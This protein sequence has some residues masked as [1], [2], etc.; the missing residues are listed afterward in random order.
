MPNSSRKTLRLLAALLL[1][2]VVGAALWLWAG[3]RK[4]LVDLVPA[5]A[6]AVIELES[7]QAKALAEKLGLPLDLNA[8]YAFITPNEYVA[9]AAEVADAKALEIT[10]KAAGAQPLEE[11]DGLQRAWLESGFLVAWKK[12]TVLAVGPE[13]SHNRAALEQTARYCFRLSAKKSFPKS[14]AYER[15]AAMDGGVRVYASI[16]ALPSPLGTLMRIALPAKCDA[17]QTAFYG[18]SVGSDAVFCLDGEIVGKNADAQSLLDEYHKATPTFA[19]SLQGAAAEVGALAVLVGSAKGPNLQP[20]LRKDA[21]LGP[22]LLG[23]EQS[24]DIGPVLNAVDGDFALRLIGLRENNEPSFVFRAKTPNFAAS[25]TAPSAR[26]VS[27]QSNGET[28]VGS[29]RSD[30]LPAA[31]LER[32]KGRSL[33]FE[34]DL[35]AARSDAA[36]SKALGDWLPRLFGDAHRLNFGIDAAGKCAL[37]VE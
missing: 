24:F 11:A 7:P 10:L 1:A 14:E 17:R 8:A 35:D 16:D 31:A 33:Y 29:D 23:M 21:L 9:L 37:R 22:L 3:G 34:A 4:S 26:F 30:Q 5:D 28:F 6:K 15:F 20:L 25:E 19:G 13:V 27:G 18:H 32:A 36:V 2:A 12:N